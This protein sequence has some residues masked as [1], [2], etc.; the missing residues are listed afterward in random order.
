LPIDIADCDIRQK[1]WFA[2]GDT[3]AD[4]GSYNVHWF[5]VVIIIDKLG[6]LSIHQ[7]VWGSIH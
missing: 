5:A 6:K 1:L 3:I 7:Q 2:L 4:N